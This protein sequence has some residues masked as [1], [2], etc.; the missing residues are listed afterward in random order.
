M[1]TT[2]GMSYED[3]RPQAVRPKKSFFQR[4]NDTHDQLISHMRSLKEDPVLSVKQGERTRASSTTSL[5]STPESDRENSQ[6]ATRTTEIDN[7]DR[8][9]SGF[10]SPPLSPVEGSF[11]PIQQFLLPRDRKPSKEFIQGMQGY[12][13]WKQATYESTLSLPISPPGTPQTSYSWSSSRS[14]KSEMSDEQMDDWLDRPM[15]AEVHRYRKV[16]ASWLEGSNESE[17]DEKRIHVIQEHPDEDDSAAREER[18]HISAMW[19]ETWCM[20][21]S[22]EGSFIEDSHSEV[23]P[24]ATE[25]V[26]AKQN[27]GSNIQS[28]L[29]SL[30]DE[31]L[32]S[33][34]LHVPQEHAQPFR[35]SCMKLNQLVTAS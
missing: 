33:V 17:E 11:F 24:E 25:D 20:Q 26:S 22:R 8:I 6:D 35:L 32:R 12:V 21:D 16:S 18:Q 29:L 7:D 28:K 9:S 5:T 15:D 4:L 2:I 23:A 19:R 30:P 13:H 31:I 14:T 3:L 10:L 27:E 1:T 34:A